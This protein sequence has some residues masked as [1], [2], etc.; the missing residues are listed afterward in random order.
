MNELEGWNRDGTKRYKRGDYMSWYGALKRFTIHGS[1]TTTRDEREVPCGKLPLCAKSWEGS[2]QKRLLVD[3][4]NNSAITRQKR[5]PQCG[6]PPLWAEF[7]EGLKQQCLLYVALPNLST[8]TTQGAH[9][10]K[11]ELEW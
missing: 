4:P 3:L 11:L 10:I 6:K 9:Q 2:D 1:T 8:I 7:G 5:K